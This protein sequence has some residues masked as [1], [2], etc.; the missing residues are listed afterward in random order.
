[1]YEPGATA[2]DVAA[3]VLAGGHS[4]RMG[5]D[6][7]LL[8]LAGQPLIAHAIATLR[9]AG[10]SPI[11]AG[12]QS[13]LSSFAP[14]IPDLKPDLGPLSGICAAIAST[15][16]QFSVFIPVDLPLLPS[17]LV[18]Y[19]VHHAQITS[20]AITIPS[21]CGV[22]NTFP[23]V[24]DRA[25]LDALK[26]ELAAGRRGCLAA[27]HAAA[28][29]LGQSISIVPVEYLVQSGHVSDPRALPAAFWFLNVNSP[30]DLDRVTG[31]ISLQFA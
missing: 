8:P 1:M 21:I 26:S 22:A 28:R 27:F 3:F 16:A 14:V 20:S 10:L 31:Q 12:A 9:D 19:L 23:A 18:A 15:S 6:K 7:A 29:T 11:I 13:D 4:S 24:L 17:S 25:V 30:D 2:S 5:R